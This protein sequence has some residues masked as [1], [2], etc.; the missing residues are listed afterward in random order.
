MQPMPS[1]LLGRRYGQPV[2]TVRMDTDRS[3]RQ[4]ELLH[5]FSSRY[6]PALE[7]DVSEVQVP[8]P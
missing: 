2:M 3:E 7:L 5:S 8:L 1:S 6:I 4:F